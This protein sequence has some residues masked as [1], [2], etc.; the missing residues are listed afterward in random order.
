MDLAAL[1][2]ADPHALPDQA[3]SYEHLAAAFQG[4]A[5]EWQS[6]V[7]ERTTG[8]GWLG[9]AADACRRALQQTDDRLIAA[10]AELRRIAA[11]LRAGADALRLAQAELA[12][13]LAEARA[14]G[15]VVTAERSGD[16]TAPL[17]PIASEA[18][19]HDPDAR[20]RHAGLTQRVRA[21]LDQADAL[22]R[23]LAD[24]LAGFTRAAADGSGLT[25]RGYAADPLVPAPLSPAVTAPDFLTGFLPPPSASP[26]AV[27]AWWRTLLPDQQQYLITTRPDLIGN[28][29]GLPATVRDQA[30][31]LLLEQ[32]LTRFATRTWLCAADQL[33]LAGF[34]AIQDR[35]D[36]SPDTPPV[37]LYG[38]SA[39]GQGRGILSFGNPDTASNVS[40]Y[41]PGLG[42]ELRCVGGKDG[43]RAMS[44]WRAAMRADPTRPTASLVWLGYDPPPGLDKGDP[45]SLDVMGEQRAR[46]GAEDYDRF[47]AGLRAGHE[48]P[49]AHL[50]ALGHSYG[51]LAVGLAAQRPAGGTQADDIILIGSPGTGTDSATHLGVGTGHV[52][53]GAADNDPVT[54]LP[55]PEQLL[56]GEGDQ[57]WFGRDPASERFGAHRFAVADGPPNSFA[58]HSNYL[59]PVGGASLPNI[60]QIVAGHPEN[61]R[62]Q[63]PR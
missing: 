8:S 5:D 18:E 2:D 36:R 1:R 35:L 55:A 25:E 52:W 39:E 58:A 7:L 20:A 22:D 24:Q 28:R 11:C 51:S 13:A 38:I 43:D 62:S 30:N 40:A 37:L 14:A 29:D 63:S 6:D 56:P 4:H 48:G 16:G 59:D 31:R 57:R 46:S 49:P 47:M 26:A 54:Y 34:R 21:A 50:V 33:K 19:R 12:S 45:E 60:G 41:V 27:A 15:F 10:R 17:A 42:T 3:E 61:V 23:A 44:V 53:V 9:S 32:Y